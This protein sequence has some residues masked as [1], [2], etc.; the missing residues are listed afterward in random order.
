[1]QTFYFHVR[2]GDLLF[3]DPYGS[4]LPDLEAALAKAL[5]AAREALI[6]AMRTGRAVYE[7]RFEIT[8]EAGRVLASIGTRDVLMPN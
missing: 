2:D 8:N 4:D 7:R 3:E 1:M 5:D 6:E